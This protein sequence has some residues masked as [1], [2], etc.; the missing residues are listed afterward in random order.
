MLRFTFVPTYQYAPAEFL[1]PNELEEED[2]DDDDG[3]EDD[4][5]DQDAEDDQ[6]DEEDQDDEDGWENSSK[7]WIPFWF[8]VIFSLYIAIFVVAFI[9]KDEDWCESRAKQ[10]A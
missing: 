7:Y 6:D 8:L 2:Q 3:Y 5:E 4:E 9:G 10:L 1:N